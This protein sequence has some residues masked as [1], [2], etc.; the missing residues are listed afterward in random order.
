MKTIQEQNVFQFSSL[1]VAGCI[2]TITIIGNFI[3]NAEIKGLIIFGFISLAFLFFIHCLNNNIKR[4]NGFQSSYI[5]TFISYTFLV[6]I[7]G[8]IYMM[9]NQE[10]E[11]SSILLLMGVFLVYGYFFN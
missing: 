7:S 6:V 3:D 1:F 11:K 5:T 2:V 9:Y 4:F 8:L 10:P